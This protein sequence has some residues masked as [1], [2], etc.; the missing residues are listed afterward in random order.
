MQLLLFYRPLQAS[1]VCLPFGLLK[2]QQLLRY[3]VSSSWFSVESCLHIQTLI[4]TQAAFSIR[5]LAGT[6]AETLQRIQFRMTMNLPNRAGIAASR[7]SGSTAGT[8]KWSNHCQVAL[9][10]GP[11]WV[12]LY[13]SKGITFIKARRKK[14]MN[15]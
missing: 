11:A 4:P 6:E 5:D 13:C 8:E 9:R 14:N 2:V 1:S 7:R 10:I 15:S 12:G 3:P